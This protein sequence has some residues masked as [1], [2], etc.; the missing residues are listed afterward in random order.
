MGSCSGTGFDV[1]SLIFSFVV[2]GI[3]FALYHVIFGAAPDQ[4]IAHEKRYP[5]FWSGACL[6]KS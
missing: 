2:G 5:E 3:F 6:W 4:R 1:E